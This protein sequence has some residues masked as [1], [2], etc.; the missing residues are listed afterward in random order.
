M[1]RS[2][3]L[4]LVLGLTAAF[5]ALNWGAF[6]TPTAL[7][8]GVTTVQAPV[9]VIMLFVLGVVSAGFVAWIVWLQG[10]VLLESRRLNREVQAQRDLADRAEASRFTELRTHIDAEM[11]KVMTRFNELEQRQRLAME[12][13]SNS[14][15]AYIGSLED[16][17]EHRSLPPEVV[18][19]D[20]RL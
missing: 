14:L 17:L 12:E 9:G 20:G 11:L 19:H 7:W 6:S 2:I 4:L 1:A 10:T 18:R 5:A 13:N 8:L 15:S 3:L 16:R